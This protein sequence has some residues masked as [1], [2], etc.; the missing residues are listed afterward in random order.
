[1]TAQKSNALNNNE[2]KIIVLDTNIFLLGIDFNMINGQLYTVPGIL[3]EIR[4][5]RYLEKN[6]NILNRIEYALSSRKLILMNPEKKYI[7]EVRQVGQKTGD[8]N[9]LSETDLNLIALTLELERTKGKKVVL[10]T[11]DYSMENVCSE[12]NL[13]YSPIAKDGIKKKR[14]YEIYCPYCREIHPSEDLG[15]KCERCGSKL[16]RRPKKSKKD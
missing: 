15:K 7:E 3:D 10:Y 13:R 2:D 14:N 1:M 12:L 9:V 16:K 8:L 5:E 4:V 6:R 11:N